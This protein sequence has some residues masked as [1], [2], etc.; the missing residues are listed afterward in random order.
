MAIAAGRISTV[1]TPSASYALVDLAT[2]KDELS[3]KITDTS[4]DTSLNRAI[5]SVSQ[6][7]ADYCS[8]PYGPFVVEALIDTFQFDRD[9]FPGL[10]FAG[11]NR[12]ALERCPVLSVTSVTQTLPDGTTR[13]LVAGTDY[14][15]N[16]KQGE[17]TRMRCDGMATRWET[18][19]LAVVYV[20]GFGALNT[21][22]P[23]T[24]PATAPYAVAVNN[25]A[26]FAF[27]QTA[28]YA[29]GTALAAV[30]A[31][32]VAGQYTVSGAGSYTFAAADAGKGVLLSYASNAIPS[33]LVSYVL[34]IITSRWSSRG[35]DPALVQRETQG[36]GIEKFWFGSE[37]G[38]DGELPPRIQAALDNT[39]RPP[40]LR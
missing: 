12:I 28:T 25:A 5:A 11:E 26:M 8:A 24:V 32:P 13:A 35:R 9:A 3:I 29:N 27:D 39:Y 4:G 31:N 6:I 10:K 33:S 2:V 14:V 22:E 21:A 7:I 40:R 16:P 37:P 1:T 23:H 19:P 17:L 18:L 20:A 15:L 30:A 36:I 38:Q 34:E